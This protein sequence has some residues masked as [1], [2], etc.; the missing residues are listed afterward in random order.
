[1]NAVEAFDCD[2]FF[3]VIKGK[4]KSLG[5]DDL[6]GQIDI[7]RG[8]V[9]KDLGAM[10][11]FAKKEFDRLDNLNPWKRFAY[12]DIPDM[13]NKMRQARYDTGDYSKPGLSG[14]PVSTQVDKHVAQDMIRFAND[15][16]ATLGTEVVAEIKKAAKRLLETAGS[17]QHK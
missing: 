10:K 14:A 11:R 3:D 15:N 9:K 12:N 2:K 1:M 7:L 4:S 5:L 6:A 16:K 13:R 8:V 17:N